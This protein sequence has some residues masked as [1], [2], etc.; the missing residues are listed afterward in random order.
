VSFAGE[1]ADVYEGFL[2]ARTLAGERFDLD[3]TE[4]ALVGRRTGRRLRL[5]D[6]VTVRVTSIEAPRGRVDLA[7]GEAVPYTWR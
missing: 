1:I 2:P 4:T 7:P 3:Q 6:P 5:G